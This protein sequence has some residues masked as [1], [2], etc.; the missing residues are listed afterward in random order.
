MRLEW[1]PKGNWGLFLEVGIEFGAAPGH[2]MLVTVVMT[3][4]DG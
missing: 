1:I 4:W 2:Q 3:L